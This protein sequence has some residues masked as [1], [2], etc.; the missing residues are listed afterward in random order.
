LKYGHAINCGVFAWTRESALMRE[1]WNHACPGRDVQRIPD[2]TCLQVILP[3]F[4]H[5]LAP[6][7]FNASCKYGDPR[8]E[9]VRI[10]HFHGNKH[11]RVTGNGTFINASDL[12]YPHHFEL[13]KF[14][15]YRRLIKYDRM[16]RH[17]APRA[18]RMLSK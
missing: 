14:D 7:T 17:C 12:W 18:E 8:S 15:W 16:L 2:E 11:C 3:M 6:A 1:W 9:G 10:V 4:K 5:K 13:V